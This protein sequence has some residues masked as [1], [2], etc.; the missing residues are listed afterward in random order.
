MIFKRN[1]SE[2][3][4]EW[5]STSNGR[6][7]LLIE[8]ARR[9]GK[10]TIVKEFV[11]KN[12]SSSIYIDFSD[13]KRSFTKNVRETFEDSDGLED[14]FNRLMLLFSVR[15]E[16]RKSAIVFDEVQKYPAAREMIKVLVDDGRYDY[17]ETG[18]LI[19]PKKNSRFILIP[20]EEE[21]VEMFP[22]GFDEFMVAIGEDMLQEHIRQ[23]FSDAKPLADGL[24]RKAMRLFRTYMAVGGMPQSVSAYVESSDYHAC[25]RIKKNII[26]L[27]REDLEK[28]SFKRAS[29]SPLII[30]D[31]M[32]SLYYNHGFEIRASEFS[33][34]TR[35]Q[36]CLNS[37]SE[38]EKSKT[39]NVAYDVIN[40][41][42][43]LSLSYDMSDVK[44]YSSDTGLLVSRIFYDSKFEDNLLY[45][46][47][48]LDKMSANEG[49]LFENVVAQML[50]CSGFALKYNTFYNGDS[51]NRRE[52]DF[53]IAKGKKIYPI[54]VKSSSYRTHTSIDEF[55][56]KHRQYIGGSYIIYSK[57]MQ[58]EDVGGK[59][60]RTY[61]PFYMVFCL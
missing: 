58:T 1:I 60:V 40:V 30:Y 27:Y 46:S 28:I 50:R 55:C 56:E 36:A 11:S 17:I 15:L 24:H 14:F 2:R 54:E 57:G 34:S 44:V 19:S 12:Y 7:A 38:L 25:D 43:T 49:F 23:S 13:T 39:V 59:Y 26:N 29:V 18:S 42:P 47:L 8:G 33:K 20:S 10:T 21:V 6:T 4:L 5:K 16:M 9:V 53:L 41:D 32:Q 35:L 37:V 52:I 45:K 48:I 61:L 3:L 51:K 31:R 22:L